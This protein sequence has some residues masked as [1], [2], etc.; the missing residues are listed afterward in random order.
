VLAMT[1][2]RS[3]MVERPL[4]ADDPK[5]RKPDIALA[6]KLLDWS[7]RVPLARGLASTIRWFHK[8]PHVMNGHLSA[9][10]D[11]AVAVDA[12]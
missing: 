11:T 2:S 12:A 8:D 4:P 10:R 6:K 5:R 7:P 9:E 1:G 3:R